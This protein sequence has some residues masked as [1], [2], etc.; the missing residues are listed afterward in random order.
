MTCFMKSYTNVH[1]IRSD[2]LSIYDREYIPGGLLNFIL[3]S[4]H[5]L[6]DGG[7]RLWLWNRKHWSDTQ[8]IGQVRDEERDKFDRQFYLFLQKYKG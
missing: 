5:L 4:C 7:C 6:L 8:S 1:H 3:M 2:N